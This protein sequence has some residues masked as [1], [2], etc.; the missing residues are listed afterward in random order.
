[1][2]FQGYSFNA[3]TYQTLILGLWQAKNDG[4][5]RIRKAIMPEKLEKPKW[6]TPKR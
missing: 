6:R 3:G 5:G 1:M 2:I 4:L